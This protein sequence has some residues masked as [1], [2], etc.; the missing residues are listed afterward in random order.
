MKVGFYIRQLML[1]KEKAMDI[2][3]SQRMERQE[4]IAWEHTKEYEAALRKAVDFEVPS[5]YSYPSYQY[6]TFQEAEEEGETSSGEA[7]SQPTTERRQRQQ[8]LMG[9]PLD[10]DDSD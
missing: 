4:S 1:E 9:Q 7:S 10:K 3:I 8:D 6:G 5:V 2:P